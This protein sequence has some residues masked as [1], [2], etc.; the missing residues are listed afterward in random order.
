MTS[1]KEFLKE[2]IIEHGVLDYSSVEGICHMNDY[3][4]TT[5]E[6]RMRE[7]CD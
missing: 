2:E 4:I 5:A 1:L 7:L 3:R 6:R